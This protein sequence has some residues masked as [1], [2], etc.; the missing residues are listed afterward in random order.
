MSTLTINNLECYSVITGGVDYASGPYIVTFNAGVTSVSFDVPIIDDD[1]LEFSEE[2]FFLI[3]D[4]S[5]LPTGFTVDNP[6]EVM[7]T[8]KDDDGEF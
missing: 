8:I 4:Q 6:N 3:I 1:I 5:S 2:I 7:V